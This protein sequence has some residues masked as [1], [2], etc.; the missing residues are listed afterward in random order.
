MKFLL[1][2]L[3][4]FS[5]TSK[6][7]KLNRTEIVTYEST[8][9]ALKSENILLG[10]QDKIYGAFIQGVTSNKNDALLAL[11]SSLEKAYKKTPHKIIQYWTAYLHYYSSI[12][13]IKLG[14]EKN[15]E[16]A[17]DQGVDIL[18][19]MKH[20]NSEDYA[21]LAMLQ[22]F[23]MQFKGM[24]VMFMA[25]EVKNNL[26]NARELDSTNVRAYYVS[27]SN[28]FYTPEKYGGGQ[29]V[30]EYLLKAIELPSQ[31]MKNEVLPSWGKDQAYELLIKHY[32]KKE[33]WEKA[34]K[35]FSEA[36]AAYPENYMLKQI[37]V[38]LVGK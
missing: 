3:L 7:S 11:Q 33:N 4:L 14:D 10:I 32:M 2:T 38:K 31:K 17:A 1:I 13:Y 28:D 36:I 8:V 19:E 15:S 16:K 27:G 12:Y 21:L 5:C 35:S 25:G 37:A 26:E 24:K 6:A 34:K 30:E 18:K 20:K 9:K 23:S 22:G 29:K